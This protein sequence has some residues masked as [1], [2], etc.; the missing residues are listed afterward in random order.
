MLAECVDKLRFVRAHSDVH[1]G[2]CVKGKILSAS[3]KWSNAVQLL[4]EW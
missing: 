3:V 4:Y 2:E 1:F